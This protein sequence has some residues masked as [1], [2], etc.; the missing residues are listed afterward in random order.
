VGDKWQ[1]QAGYLLNRYTKR[2]LYNLLKKS[3]PASVSILRHVIPGPEE[4]SGN[5]E[6]ITQKR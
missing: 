2:F 3:I 4:I 6:Q 1:E 5:G